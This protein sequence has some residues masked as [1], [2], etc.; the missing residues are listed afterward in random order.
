MPF[1]A[2]KKSGSDFA[3]GMILGFEVKGKFIT[4]RDSGRKGF[5]DS[6]FR[7]GNVCQRKVMC[8]LKNAP[9]LAALKRWDGKKTHTYK[10]TL[11]G[12]NP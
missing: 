1:R 12:T 4:V 8:T 2:G 3:I 6:F 5:V 7:R 9:S 11:P 10:N